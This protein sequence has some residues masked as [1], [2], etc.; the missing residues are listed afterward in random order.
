MCGKETAARYRRPVE[1]SYD[2][3]VKQATL[4]FVIVESSCS[5]K[6]EEF[7]RCVF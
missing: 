5:D 4:L 2:G 1:C 6:H 7:R 3:G